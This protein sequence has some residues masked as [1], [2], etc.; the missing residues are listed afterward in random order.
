MLAE[1]VIEVVRGWLRKAW[2]YVVLAAAVI[3]AGGLV[4]GT[5]DAWRSPRALYREAT[6]AAPARA[7][8][9]YA[10]LEARAPEL[11]EYYRLWSAQAAMPS[12]DAVARLDEVIRYRPDSPAAYQAHLTLARYYAT[13]ESPRTVEEY[14]AALTLDQSVA[15][16]LELADYL[17]EQNAPAA[18]YKQYL[19][20]LGRE[21]VDAFADMRRT[22]ADPLTAAQDL[23]QRHFYSDVLDILRDAPTCQ[24]HCLR[25]KAFTALGEAEAAAQETKACEACSAPATTVDNTGGSAKGPTAPAAGPL[26]STNPVDWWSATW[27]MDVEATLSHTLPI[28][29]VL[30]IYLKVA[31][32]GA[33]VAD[34][35]AYRAWVLARRAGDTVAEGHALALLKTMQP[36]WYLWLATQ[37]LGLQLTPPFP[38]AAVEALAADVLRKVA[39]L[40]TLGRPDLALKELQLTARVSETPELIVRLAQALT[41]RGRALEA[42]SLAVPL[43]KDHPRMPASAWQLA[44]P[45]AYAV[46]VRRWAVQYH[47]EPE[48]LWAVMR[49]ESACNPDDTSSAGAMGLL[50]LMPENVTEANAALGTAYAPGDAYVPEVNIRLAAWQLGQW[51]TRYQG[52]VTLALMAYNAGPGSVDAW[53]QEPTSRN[54]EDLLRFIPYGETREYVSQV[55]LNYQIYRMLY[56]KAG[57]GG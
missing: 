53:L 48:L 56:G 25:A 45:Q 12:L 24:A 15:V 2:P 42:Y 55:S 1:R 52:D 36:N 49:Q 18:A 3:V 16:A 13:L 57:A 39:A 46:E 27:D 30:A 5:R 35:A 43:L 26:A 34:D 32:S 31:G 6:T 4:W 14:K 17:E 51:L 28:S 20:L 37:D 23:L 44:Y 54:R 40:E 47:V 10:R 22:A 41:A 11:S 21:R 19:D 29:E 50:Q 33:Y 9:L 7:A 8:Q 38:D